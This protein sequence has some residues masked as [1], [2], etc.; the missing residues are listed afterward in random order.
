VAFH[1][2]SFRS[3]VLATVVGLL[4]LVQGAVLLAV[5]VA[6][7]RQARTHARE[8][9]ELTA[10]AFRRSLEVRERILVEKARLL[11]SDFAFKQ[12]IATGDRA[13][14]LSALENHRARVG[15]DVMLLLEPS[16]EVVAD[17]L[18][19]AARDASPDLMPL[20]ARAM[21][22]DFGEAASIDAL[23]GTPYQLVVVPLFMPEPSAW[24]VIGFRIE[25]SLARQLQAETGTHVSL[26]RRGEG[27]WEAFC[28]TLPPAERRALEEGRLE[29]LP[30][31][32]GIRNLQLAGHEYVSWVAR[33]D[34][35]G[36]PVVAV[37]QRSLEEAL[38]PFLRLR[39][40]LFAIFG[41][42]IALSLAGSV[43]LAG[44]VT[45]PV[46]DLARG[47]RRIERGNYSDPVVVEQRDELGTL[48]SS[49]NAMMKGLA[50][51]DQV[52]DLLG[53]VVA[54]EIAEELLRTEI[55]LGGEERRV[56]VLFADVQGFTALSE[57]EPPQRLVRI[58]NA[59]LGA[60]S[61][62]IEAHGG[63]VEEYMGDGAKALFGAPV[64]HD[65]DALRAVRAGLALQASLPA[66]NAEIAALGA[67]PLSIGIGIHTG[68]VVAGKMG[69]LSRLKYTV[70]GD[71][72]NLASRLEGLTRRYGVP[73]I[74]SAPTRER[75]PG[76]VFR[77][78]DRVR[79]KGRGAPVV[80][81][82]PLGALEDVDAPLQELAEQHGAAL[83][84]LRARDWERAAAAF[85]AL[86]RR[87]PG[88]RL[89]RLYLER[90]ARLRAEPPGPDWDGTLV[91]E[92]K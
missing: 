18:H 5:H 26:V 57:R 38:R 49:F 10:A 92:E 14:I 46:A 81:Y 90:I 11:S 85:E 17:T 39:A 42:G 44:G 6:N 31:L 53:R 45:R 68:N 77:E 15:A 13:T 8:A 76:L 59:F 86:G 51:R 3:R 79:V 33:L 70:V 54:P 71:G 35:V 29:P 2:R 47:A 63:V 50:E 23:D 91:L 19:P 32:P 48:A 66:V 27:G 12:V 41:L 89:Y 88:T 28:T 37:L 55:E 4:V 67:A 80:V 69:S 84:R 24:I 56:S 73:I 43:L 16:G 83:E 7:L 74:V 22:D 58:L 34:D 87:Q 60:V 30:D 82:E 62:A 72:V 21:E 20:V 1:F 52:R 9:L 65:D 40:M 25:D 75:C 36:I 61:A 64:A 78:L